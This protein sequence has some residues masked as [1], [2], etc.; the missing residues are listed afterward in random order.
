MGSCGFA[1]FVSILSNYARSY[2]QQEYSGGTVK[3]QPATP[4][5]KYETPVMVDLGEVMRGYGACTSG[6]APTGGVGQ[7]TSGAAAKGKCITGAV[8]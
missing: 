8:R 1:L 3:E 7:C 6:G 2:V 5:K 4:T